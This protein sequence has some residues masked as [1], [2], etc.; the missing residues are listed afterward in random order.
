MAQEP[1]TLFLP[2]DKLGNNLDN[3]VTDEIHEVSELENII[4]PNMGA[5]YASSLVIKAID[6]S[7]NETTLIRGLD[8]KCLNFF[9][10]TT[11]ELGKEICGS[12]IFIRPI[13][14]RKFN[15]T[16]QA[17]GSDRYGNNKAIAGFV[18]DTLEQGNI[19]WEDIVGKP[20]GFPPTPNHPHEWRDIY[21][22][23]YLVN[24]LNSLAQGIRDTKNIYDLDIIRRLKKSAE[25][26][27]INITSLFS[28]NTYIRNS[29]NLL[30]GLTSQTS[31][32]TNFYREYNAFNYNRE[33]SIIL[34][35]IVNDKY[36][37]HPNY[38]DLYNLPSKIEGLDF[39]IDFS[40]VSKMII[41]GS[42]KIDTITDKSTK[43]RVFAQTVENLK[44]TSIDN[45]DYGLSKIRKNKSA[46]FLTNNKLV[47]SSGDPVNIGDN[48]TLVI[49]ARIK[50]TPGDVLTS[51]NST[52]K[53]TI[54]DSQFRVL[55]LFSQKYLI[56]TT[57]I[58]TSNNEFLLNFLSVGDRDKS[59]IWNINNFGNQGENVYG[60]TQFQN[61]LTIENLV[62]NTLGNTSVLG[63]DYE[64]SE[65]MIFNRQLS[66]IEAESIK[67]YLSRKWVGTEDIGITME[68]DSLNATDPTPESFWLYLDSNIP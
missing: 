1:V 37:N 44:P 20:L 43:A 21:G 45:P 23:E 31:F 29:R 54:N 59:I 57:P 36:S 16:Y 6:G 13:S 17:L 14:Q 65:I 68:L 40:D 50:T 39:W 48:F 7:D 46:R 25:T 12:I 24:M 53:L 3:R 32:L 18:S 55:N 28:N 9:E 67:Q 38:A 51:S 26:N 10:K 60:L 64:L 58:T 49:L 61:N 27:K 33:L 62:F 47:Q 56:N 15:L 52:D 41:N 22:A 34:S 4:K 19:N 63:Q 5:F 8:Y 11:A 35:F 42:N 2:I 66:L 30:L